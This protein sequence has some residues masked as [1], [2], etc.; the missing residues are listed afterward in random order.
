M[1]SNYNLRPRPA[2]VVV[3]G[4]EHRIVRAAETE[5]ELVDRELGKA[6]A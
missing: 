3:R 6:N 4:A 1:A 5:R 2:E